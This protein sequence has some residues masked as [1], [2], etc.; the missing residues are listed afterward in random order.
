MEVCFILVTYSW[1]SSKSSC[2]FETS[3]SRC[4]NSASSIALREVSIA[5]WCPSRSSD[6]RPAPLPPPPPLPEPARPLS[7]DGEVPLLGFALVGGEVEAALRRDVAS[8][9]SL[10]KDCSR[11]LNRTARKEGE[12]KKKRGGGCVGN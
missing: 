12:K 10:L 1:Y 11:S 9:S 6:R 7:R 8:S 4:L 5:N 3:I 2:S